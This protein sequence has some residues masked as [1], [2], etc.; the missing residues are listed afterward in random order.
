[1]LGMQAH[2]GVQGGGVHGAP[3]AREHGRQ[4][5]HCPRVHVWQHPQGPQPLLLQ[6]LKKTDLMHSDVQNAESITKFLLQQNMRHG[7]FPMTQ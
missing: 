2:S 3:D 7:V 4:P 1:M 6:P 5:L